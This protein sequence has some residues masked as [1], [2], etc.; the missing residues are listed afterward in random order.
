MSP[1]WRP[2]IANPF[3]RRP[4]FTQNGS[5]GSVRTIGSA[6]STKSTTNAGKYGSSP[7]ESRTG[8][9]YLLVERR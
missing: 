2:E 8:T 3:S 6:C 1:T 4:P 7:L 5:Y 9:G